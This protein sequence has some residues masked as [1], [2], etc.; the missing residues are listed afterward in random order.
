MTLLP[1][2]ARPSFVSGSCGGERCWC[3]EPATH[4]VEETIFHDDPL[5][6]RH[7]LTSYV[8]HWHFVQMMGPAAQAND[9]RVRGQAD[10]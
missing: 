4:K 3:G 1:K 5:P 10:G 8:C 6:H 2:S 9:E 7:P